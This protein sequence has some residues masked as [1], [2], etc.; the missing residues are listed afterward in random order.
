M[1]GAGPVEEG[2]R[3]LLEAEREDEPR[4]KWPRSEES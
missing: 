1:L 3:V 4:S 2:L